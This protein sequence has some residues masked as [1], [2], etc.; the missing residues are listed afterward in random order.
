MINCLM[1]SLAFDMYMLHVVEL[2]VVRL[3]SFQ[4]VE[5]LVQIHF[6][7]HMIQF[8]ALIC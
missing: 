1:F 7:N 4:H 3:Y 5:L 2:N 8:S 6:E